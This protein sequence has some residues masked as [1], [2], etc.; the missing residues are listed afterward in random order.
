M[1]AGKHVYC[2]KPMSH[3]IHEGEPWKTR[4]KNTIVFYKQEVC[5]VQ[6]LILERPE[7]V[8]N[9]Y[10]GK[11]ERIWVEVGNPSAPCNLPFQETP[12]YLN[13]DRWLGPAPLRSYHDIIVERDWFPNWRWYREFGGGILS[14]WEPYV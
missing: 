14:D 9:G 10:I 11:I 3:T 5:S 2:E 7:L 13:W 12:D 1:K 4:Q 8:R 6:E